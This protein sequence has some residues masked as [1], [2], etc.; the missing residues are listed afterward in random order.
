M[1]FYPFKAV[2]PRPDRIAQ[3]PNYFHKARENFDQL[4]AEG[5]Y[6]SLATAGLYLLHIRLPDG[7]NCYGLCGL[8]DTQEY[9]RADGRGIRPHE[10]TLVEQIT[11]HRERM[12]EQAALIKPVL[13]TC[14]L[15]ADFHHCLPALCEEQPALLQYQRD[16]INIT[17]YHLTAAAVITELCQAIARHPGLFAVADG[18][19]RI[20]TVQEAAK[21]YGEKYSRLPVVILPENSLGVDTFI[22][23]ISP[24][25]QAPIRLEALEA[26]FHIQPLEAA[27]LPSKTGQ[28]LL[29]H[30][31][32]FYHLEAKGKKAVPDAVW[33]NDEVLPGLFGILDSRNDPRI[34]SKEATQ[35]VALLRRLTEREPLSWHFWGFPLPM[36]DFHHC[37]RNGQL[38]PP[39]STYFFPRIP[40][41][42]LVYDF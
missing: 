12:L 5:A 16:G 34:Q 27:Q 3:S 30:Q 11:A 35:E 42:L 9:K 36:S 32:K 39:K 2:I 6:T 31:G 17:L 25:P 29:A 10:A 23:S 13:L 1:D 14:S 20:T 7:R 18:H 4:R 33:F 24:A 19:H 37:I 28:W 38:L 8:I 26:Y 22:R 21:H 15:I 40:T 41:G